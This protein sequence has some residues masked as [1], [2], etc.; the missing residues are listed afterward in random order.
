MSRDWQYAYV[1][2]L[3]PTLTPDVAGTYSL[4]LQAQLEFPDR[5]FPGASRSV[6]TLQVLVRP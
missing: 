6:A 3:V 1:D 2:G 5:A 4:Q